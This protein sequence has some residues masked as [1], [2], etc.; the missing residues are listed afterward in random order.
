MARVTSD[1]AFYLDRLKETPGLGLD[2]MHSRTWDEVC[3][4]PQEI[5]SLERPSVAARNII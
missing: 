1:L 2:A 5:D 3:A 4:V